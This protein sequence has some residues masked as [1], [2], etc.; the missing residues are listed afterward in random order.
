MPHDAPKPRIM[1]SHE[2]GDCRHRHLFNQRHHQRFKHE[3]E[4]T[5]GARPRH[6]YLADFVLGAF[7][8]R[9]SRAEK[10][11]T[12][13]EIHVSPALDLAVVDSARFAAKRTWKL[14]SFF[15]ID[16][17]I[18]YFALPAAILQSAPNY[19]PRS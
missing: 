10:S 2:R 11:R 12:L 18:Q 3:R 15:K 13:P 9:H 16:V 8:P 1:F 17:H 7:D 6:G 19:L 4:A 5:F 14:A